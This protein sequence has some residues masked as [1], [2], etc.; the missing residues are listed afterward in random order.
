MSERKEELTSK[1]TAP[2]PLSQPL[3]SKRYGTS[4][5]TGSVTVVGSATNWTYF[6]SHKNE[7]ILRTEIENN[8]INSRHVGTR[9]RYLKQLTHDVQLSRFEELN[10]SLNYGIKCKKGIPNAQTP[11]IISSRYIL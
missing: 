4:G 5:N 11:S 9:Y 1:E 6:G 2:P 10:S 3:K 8:C 7:W